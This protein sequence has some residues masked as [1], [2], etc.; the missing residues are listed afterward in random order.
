MV[1]I[2]AVGLWHTLMYQTL[3][4]VLLSLG[5]SKYG[6]I[7]NGVYCFT[8]L[9]GIPLAFHFFGL[10]GAI[11]AVAAGDFPLYLVTVFG[12]TREGVRPLKQ[13]GLLTL[14]FLSLL[15]CE[16]ALRNRFR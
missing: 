10:L 2:L 1:P 5:K 8:I 4:P 16:F 14:G 7:G 3:G 11:I 9:A 12:A 6:A 13:D 15:A